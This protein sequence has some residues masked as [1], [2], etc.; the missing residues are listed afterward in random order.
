V[1]AAGAPAGAIR[2]LERAH[3]QLIAG[4]LEKTVRS[5]R[6]VKELRPES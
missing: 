1:T 2:E 5:A 6:V 3:A 4:H